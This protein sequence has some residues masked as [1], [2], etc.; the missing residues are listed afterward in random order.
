MHAR[1]EVF[2][3]GFWFLFIKCN[4]CNCNQIGMVFNSQ[5]LFVRCFSYYVSFLFFFR[6]LE[7][8]RVGPDLLG[9]NFGIESIFCRLHVCVEAFSS[10]TLLVGRQEGHP[11]CKKLSV[12][13]WRGYLSGARCRLAYGPADATATH[14]LLLQ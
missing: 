13:C 6:F 8:L 14:C 3:I 10:L 7:L 11:A 5:L 2:P 9:E 12:G 1:A 4:S